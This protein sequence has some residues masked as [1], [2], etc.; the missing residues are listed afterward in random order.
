MA[1]IGEGGAGH[2][3]AVG[4]A[5]HRHF[6][7]LGRIDPVAAEGGVDQPVLREHRLEAIDEIRV[8]GLLGQA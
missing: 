1:W 7:R 6:Q 8:A 5:Q 2:Q 4:A 3:H